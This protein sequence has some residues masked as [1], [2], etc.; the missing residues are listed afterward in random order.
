MSASTRYSASVFA[1]TIQWSLW[2]HSD[3][4][5]WNRLFIL[6]SVFISL[7]S[8]YLSVHCKVRLSQVD[9]TMIWAVLSIF[10]KSIPFLEILH[11]T[12]SLYSTRACQRRVLNTVIW[13][14]HTNR[15]W[16][17]S[18]SERLIWT[19]AQRTITVCVWCR[20]L[21]SPHSTGR[22]IAG[23]G[24]KCWTLTCNRK[25]VVLRGSA[26]RRIFCYVHSTTTGESA[27][28]LRVRY[29]S[30]SA[31]AALTSAYFSLHR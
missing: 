1:N 28:Y 26:V 30:Q 25:G 21:T 19:I 6:M 27:R 3:N 7:S 23:C 5:T 15:A 9:N 10:Y 13:S 24:P 18:Q 20:L 11:S 8:N 2:L 29:V 22:S 16:F 14:P 31:S 4:R 12:R 17:H